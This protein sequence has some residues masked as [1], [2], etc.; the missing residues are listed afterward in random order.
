MNL[1]RLKIKELGGVLYEELLARERAARVLYCARHPEKSR[2]ERN[3]CKKR[4]P[5]RTHIVSKARRRGRSLG[6]EATITVADIIWPTHCPVLGLKLFYPERRG[7]QHRPRHD[8]ASLDRWDNTKGYVAGNVF[9]ISMRANTLK[10]DATAEEL[11][12][13]SLYARR[14]P[15]VEAPGLALRV[16]QSAVRAA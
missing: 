9:V 1:P 3:L 13:V 7:E 16:R 15:N 2:I 6:L 10:N 4:S 5:W 14:K 8:W 11:Q 12:A